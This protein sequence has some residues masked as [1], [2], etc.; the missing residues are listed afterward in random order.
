MY[1]VE[2]HF[3]I[4]IPSAAIDMEADLICLSISAGDHNLKVDFFVVADFSAGIA[5]DGPLSKIVVS[6]RLLLLRL[7]TSVL[8]RLTF[9]CI[10]SLQVTLAPYV[11][12]KN[13]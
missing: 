10:L 6:N 13:Y 11:A 9:L 12:L 1:T 7:G 4:Y 8:S 3:E 5:T 2:V